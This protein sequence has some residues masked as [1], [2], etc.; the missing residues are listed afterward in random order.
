[1]KRTDRILPEGERS[2]VQRVGLAPSGEFGLGVRQAD[3]DADDRLVVGPCV[4]SPSA[5]AR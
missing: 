2:K 3:D 4:F 5:R 1:M